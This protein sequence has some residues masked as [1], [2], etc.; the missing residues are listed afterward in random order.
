M[1]LRLERGRVGRRL[2]YFLFPECKLG[3]HTGD[4]GNGSPAD[5]GSASLGS[6]PRSPTNRVALS[7]RGLGRRP[8]TAQTGVRIPIGSPVFLPSSPKCRRGGIGRRVRLRGV[9]AT[10]RVQV[11]PPTPVSFADVA[12]LADAHGSGPCRVI[13]PGGSSSLPI[14]T[15][16]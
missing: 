12:E 13:T 15:I 7:S 11:P 4:W 3:G 8:L 2:N 5:S 6:N 16:C 10:V 14:C 1:V 9:W